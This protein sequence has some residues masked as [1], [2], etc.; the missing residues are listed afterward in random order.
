MAII[1]MCA[2]STTTMAQHNA[3]PK[4]WAWNFPQGINI[5]ARARTTGP[6]M[7]DALLRPGGKRRGI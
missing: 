1:A 7:P 3:D 4:V 5:Q 2:F 6:V